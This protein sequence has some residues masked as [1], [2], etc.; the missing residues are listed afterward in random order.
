MS[1][2]TITTLGEAR[3]E[4][5][6]R[7]RAGDYAAALRLCD[8]LMAVV[9]LDYG[10]RLRVADLLARVGL[11]EEGAEV[12]R[13]VAVHDIRSGHPLPAVVACAALD[14]LG[15]PAD[16]LREMLADGYAAGSPQLARFAVRQAPVAPGTKVPPLPEGAE[17][18]DEL[19]E[20]AR[21]R[22]LDLS[23]FPPYQPQVHPVPFL[24]ELAREPFL[25]LLRSIEVLRLEDGALVTRQGDPG[26]ALY[27]MAGGEV[28]VFVQDD[29][30]AAATRE[31]ARLYEGT[32]FGEMAL[33][34]G[35][36]RSASV[37]AV[38]TADVLEVNRRTLARVTEELPVIRAVLDRFTR[39]RLIK[40]LLQTSPLFTPFTPAQ[41]SEL[42]RR[43]EGHDVEPGT[44]VL[45]QGEPGVGLFVVLSG[46]LEVLA[47]ADDGTAVPLG[48]LATGDIFGEMSLLTNQPA[49]ATVRASTRTTL[50]FLARTY[51]ERLAVAIPE[52][53]AYFESVA[54]Q[55]ARDNTLRLAGR[56]LPSGEIEIDPSHAILI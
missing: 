12:Y 31:V 20:R 46:A 38:V 39:E 21:R 50:L 10:V 15:R 1:T 55:R 14:Q 37:T 33:V 30:A 17:P 52:V 45:R 22:A 5:E 53:R 32:V 16:D 43:F 24:S 2:S 49:S 35:Q 11:V 13:T 28:R 9:P 56:A 40:N 48:K 44:E 54:V 27:L 41:Q 18:F 23:P 4:A 29:D 34:T 8:H 3:A 26:D 51:V 6:E 42:L 7:L 19:A 36:P 25:A 47:R